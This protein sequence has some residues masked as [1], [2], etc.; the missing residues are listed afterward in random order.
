LVN[1]LISGKIYLLGKAQTKQP[2]GTG[3]LYWY[4]SPAED[5][6]LIQGGKISSS[7]ILFKC[8]QRMPPDSTYHFTRLIKA[9]TDI[10]A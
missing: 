3:T 5:F 4:P 6:Y 9:L 8:F 1:L 7:R 10:G 2:G